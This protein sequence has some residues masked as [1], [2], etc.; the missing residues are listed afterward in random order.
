MALYFVGYDVRAVTRAELDYTLSGW[1]AVSLYDGAWLLNRELSAL[2][3]RNALQG[4]LHDDDAAIVLELKPGS[5]WASEHVER[6]AL[7]WL[8]AHV[9]A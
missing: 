4:Y 2:E 7:E 1:G 5:W 8:K 9:L 3:V 6:G